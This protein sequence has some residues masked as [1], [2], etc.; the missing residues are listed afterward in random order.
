MAGAWFGALYGY[1]TVFPSNYE[2]LEYKDRAEDLA[3]KL[4]K[5]A[6]P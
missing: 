5:L 6:F 3:D 2:A 4:F 1:D